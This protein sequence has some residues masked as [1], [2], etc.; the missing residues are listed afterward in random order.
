[1]RL[2]TCTLLAA[3]VLCIGLFACFGCGPS[4]GAGN[5][6]VGSV[7][8]SPPVA[9]NAA[10]AVQVQAEFAAVLAAERSL[11]KENTIERPRYSAAITNIERPAALPEQVKLIRTRQK[12][13]L[14]TFNGFNRF[15]RAD[16]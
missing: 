14:G 7:Q 13:K 3:L 6:A 9:D 1:M 10:Q 11:I 12:P 4:T 15:A 16:V 5:Q 8:K 2:K